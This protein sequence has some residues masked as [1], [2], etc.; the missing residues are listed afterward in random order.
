[1][2]ASESLLW[3]EKGGFNVGIG[4]GIGSISSPQLPISIAIATPIP[5]LT[6]NP[7]RVLFPE[8]PLGFRT[9]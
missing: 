3:A 6:G 5:I 2:G 7:I 8:Q 1:M 4:I 9:V